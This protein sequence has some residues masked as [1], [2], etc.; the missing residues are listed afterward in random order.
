MDNTEEQRE[1][2]LTEKEERVCH[3]IQELLNCDDGPEFQTIN[4]TLLKMKHEAHLQ[5]LKDDEM[6]SDA[7]F[8]RSPF[9]GPTISKRPYRRNGE[10]Y[11]IA[12][13]V[14]KELRFT[15]V[16]QS[17]FARLHEAELI[18]REAQRSFKRERT[19]HGETTKHLN[20]T[21]VKL[22]SA[23]EEIR[24]LKTALKKEMGA[25]ASKVIIDKITAALE[26]RAARGF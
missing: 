24:R 9:C 10:A 4:H 5:N 8:S 13:K 26:K 23:N 17:V 22:G 20:E 7:F 16:F 21:V 18:W 12:A 2:K 1:I 11:E 25:K 19:L 15:R 3:I 14:L 6:S